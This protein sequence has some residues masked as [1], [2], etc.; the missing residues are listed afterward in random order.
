LSFKSAAFHFSQELQSLKTQ[1]LTCYLLSFADIAH[2]W[3]EAAE[4]PPCPDPAPRHG[5]AAT[6]ASKR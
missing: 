3:T 4:L 5:I 1:T 2:L 6:L